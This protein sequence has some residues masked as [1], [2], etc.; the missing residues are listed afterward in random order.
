M[1]NKVRT[2]LT[3]V[4]FRPIPSKT[5]PTDQH[6]MLRRARVPVSIS[7]SELRAFGRKTVFPWREIAFGL[8]FLGVVLMIWGDVY[9]FMTLCN[10]MG[11]FGGPR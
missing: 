5:Q 1:P 7:D 3:V 2:S 8:R 6:R 10:R 11:W 9:A 4:K